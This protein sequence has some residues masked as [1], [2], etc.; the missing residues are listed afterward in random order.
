MGKNMILKQYLKYHKDSL[1]KYGKSIVL[2]QVGSFSEIYGTLDGEGP[3]LN[4]ISNITNCSIAMKCKDSDNAHYM[5]GWPKIADC[6]YIPL[7]IN[8]DF[9]DLVVETHLDFINAVADL[10]VTNNFGVI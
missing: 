10:I 6:K 1:E 5:I 8:E 3:D 7:L 2:M 9:H 4:H